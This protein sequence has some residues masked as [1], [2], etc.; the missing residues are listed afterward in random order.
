MSKRKTTHST[1][2]LRPPKKHAAKHAAKVYWPYL[3]LLVLLF[4][5]MIINGLRPFTDSFGGQTLAYATEMSRGNLLSSTNS[6]RAANGK[7]SLSLNSLLNQ[8]AQN[9][10]TDMRNDNYWAHETP[11]GEQP[12]I[13]IDAVGYVYTKA[14]E[15]LAYGYG[16]SDATITGWMNSPS[17]KANML[18]STF[19]EVGFG[20]INASD[21]MPRTA[22]DYNS[23]TSVGNQTIV[24]AMYA[25]P[26]SAQ[27]VPEP[28]P[29]PV[30]TPE[31]QPEVQSNSAEV[32]QAEEEPVVEVK[33]AEEEEPEVELDDDSVVYTDADPINTDSSQEEIAAAEPV[34]TTFITQ[35]TSGRYLW[36]TTAIS[37]FGFTLSLAWLMKHFVAVR[38][39]VI[40]GEHFVA[41]HPIFDLLVV[42]IILLAIYL[43]QGNG[44]VL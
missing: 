28:T 42:S 33:P 31:P 27:P 4:G 11:E 37:L 39:I 6:R 35:L 32:A 13:F 3:P 5:G 40:T 17:H 36:A 20:F 26:Y 8:A 25:K 2:G 23:T 24:V 12:W 9:K 22:P 15:N 19:T 1:K 14:G 38:K 16:T 7:S 30:T 21:Y 18:D 44:V 29:Q 43:T 10:A 34:K 41:H